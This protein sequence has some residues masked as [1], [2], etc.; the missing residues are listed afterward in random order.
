MVKIVMDLNNKTGVFGKITD[1]DGNPV[2]DVEVYI[3]SS[4]VIDGSKR[5]AT[6]YTNS[7][8]NFKIIGLV[9]GRYRIGFYKLFKPNDTSFLIPSEEIFIKTNFMSELNKKIKMI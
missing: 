9:E 3:S 1:L 6:T 7:K 5:N 8:G 2:E 4:K